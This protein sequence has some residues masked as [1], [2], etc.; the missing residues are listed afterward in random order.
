MK[1]ADYERQGKL[2]KRHARGRTG[3]LGKLVLCF[4]WGQVIPKHARAVEEVLK[5]M[6]LGE[7]RRAALFLF[8]F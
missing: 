8:L 5:V 4:G 7:K 3:T 6:S 2:K 1:Q